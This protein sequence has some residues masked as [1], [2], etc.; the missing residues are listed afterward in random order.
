MRLAAREESWSKEI[1]RMMS[2]LLH[3]ADRESGYAT[4]LLS[5]TIRFVPDPA[6]VGRSYC[7][8]KKQNS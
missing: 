8:R 3:A 2:S 5:R 6:L 4:E 1:A 7:R